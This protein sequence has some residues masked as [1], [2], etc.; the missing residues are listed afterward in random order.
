MIK[1]PKIISRLF[2]ATDGTSA[3]EFALIAPVFLLVLVGIIDLGAVI[4]DK[5]ELN[6]AAATAARYVLN[7][8][9]S[10]SNLVSVAT[11]GSALDA[12]DITA[13]V[14]TVCGCSG[15]VS[16]QCGSVCTDGQAPG[17]YMLVDL[18]KVSTMILPYPGFGDM[19]ING[20]SRMRLD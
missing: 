3:V 12:N 16:A 1:W 4:R 6:N 17:T 11:S 15:G 10:E 20:Q 13:T 18:T 9:Y 19:T 8:N 5:V 14:S 7:E 2:G